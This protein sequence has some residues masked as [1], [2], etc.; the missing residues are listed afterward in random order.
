MGVEEAA[1][2]SA[3][4]RFR[5]ILM[6]AFAFILGVVPLMRASGA[7][8]GAQNV[9][10]T[11]VFWGMLVATALGVFLIPGNYAFVESLGRKKE[12]R[13]P[14]RRRPLPA[15]SHGGS[16]LTWPADSLAALPRPARRRLRA[17]VRTTSGRP[18]RHRPP[19]ANIPAAEAE[20]LANTPWWE[21]FDDPQLQELVRIALQE[22]KDLKIAVER[23]EEARARYGFTKADLWPK[24]DLN[25]TAGRLR[26]NSG[27]LV[28]TPEGDA[29]TVTEGTET[30]IY[31]LSAD[32]S[33]EIDFFGRIRRAT[34]AQKALFLGTQ[35]ARRAAVIDAGGGR[36]PRVPGDAGLRPPARGGDA[37][38][39]VAT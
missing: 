1:L 34:E 20:N 33:W 16:A 24:V 37:H 39:R 27:S 35:E 15:P 10:G 17:R 31:A 18:F 26:F 38:D 23:I 13:R 30:P 5:P 8:A 36:G 22:N 6:T 28:H 25:A 2:E 7:G 14:R 32:V 4:L 11:A 21:L 3:R 12:R 29:A 19:G 9:M